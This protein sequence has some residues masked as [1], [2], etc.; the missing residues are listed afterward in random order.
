MSG[1]IAVVRADTVAGGIGLASRLGDIVPDGRGMSVLWHTVSRM[2]AMKRIERVVVLHEAGDDI[3]AVL[4]GCDMGDRVV[5][6]AIDAGV[7]RDSDMGKRIAARKWASGSWRGGLGGMTCYDE[8][9]PIEPVLGAVKKYSAEGV[10]LVGGD[11]MLVDPVFNDQL[12]DRHHESVDSMSFVF[13]QSPVGLAGCLITC[14]LLENMVESKSTMGLIL[15]Y[16]PKKVQADPI[17]H[18]VCLPVDPVV[19][20]CVTRFVY[21][22]S[23]S[24]LLFDSMAEVMG[25]DLLS[26]DQMEVVAWVNGMGLDFLND[27]LLPEQVSVELTPK[28]GVKGKLLPQFYVDFDRGDLDFVMG[29]K[30]FEEMGKQG[31]VLLNLGGL[32]DPLEHEQFFE[33]VKS[34][35]AKGVWGIH[36]ETDLGVSDAIVD[37]LLTCGVDVI[38]MRIHVDKHG[39]YDELIC[40]DDTTRFDLVISNVERLINIR[41]NSGSALPWL[42]PIMTKVPETIDQVEPFFDRWTHFLGHAVIRYPAYGCGLMPSL[43]GTEMH[44]PK[45][46]GCRQLPKRMTV[47][48]DGVVALCDQDWQGEGQGSGG[49]LIASSL[50]EVW[51]GMAG[52]RDM[53]SLK[54]WEEMSLCGKC[55]EWHRP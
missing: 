35:K 18:D 43:G 16:N 50:L 25:D 19:R 17:A 22:M 37:E 45:R 55:K 52:V 5:F 10:V 38:S 33:F 3:G 8:L 36:V 29:E 51:Q 39:T 9:L 2:A 21:D 6:E 23:R 46:F 27:A 28:R 11:W 32:G 48:S 53:H 24:R 41:N 44:P 14:K 34:A 31:D 7:F 15:D 40:P 13:S 1:F 26:A 42:V 30:I 4:G 47:L 20:G 54:L 12:I 49:D